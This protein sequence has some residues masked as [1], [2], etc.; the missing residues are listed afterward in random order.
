MYFRNGPVECRALVVKKFLLF[1]IPIELK[2]DEIKIST[3]GPVLIHA[4]NAY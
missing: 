2:T 1:L 4:S 3:V